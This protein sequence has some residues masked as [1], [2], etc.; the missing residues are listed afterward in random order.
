MFR[1]DNKSLK[2]KV[3]WHSVIEGITFVYTSA[4]LVKISILGLLRSEPK[5]TVLLHMLSEKY[6]TPD[7]SFQRWNV[8][9]VMTDNNQHPKQIAASPYLAIWRD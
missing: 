7:F 6:T 4:C 1:T 3:L 8:L 5:H 2:S 9:L